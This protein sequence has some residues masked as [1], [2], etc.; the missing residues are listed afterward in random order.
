MRL[1]NEREMRY[2]R[3][4]G[5]QLQMMEK[6]GKKGS[7]V[8][9]NSIYM[10]SLASYHSEVRFGPGYRIR[11][12]QTRDVFVVHSRPP[13]DSRLHSFHQPNSPFSREISLDFD[14]PG[15]SFIQSL[16][17]SCLSIWTKR[18]A[19]QVIVIPAK[20]P[21]LRTSSIP[22]MIMAAPRKPHMVAPNVSIPTLMDLQ[23]F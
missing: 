23:P 6:L 20:A 21:A 19:A 7:V 15:L 12:K 13:V 14:E 1:T 2:R 9:K 11:R 5:K 3:I 10:G 4:E 8:A 17:W 16:P 18:R 22:L